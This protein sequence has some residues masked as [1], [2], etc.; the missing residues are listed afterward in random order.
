MDRPD[1][2]VGN[3]VAVEIAQRGQGEAKAIVVAQTAD[4]TSL[5]RADLPVRLHRPVGVEEQHPHRATISAPVVI[6][7][8][9]D[10]QV[11]DAVAVQI[12]QRGHR[13]AEEIAIAQDARKAALGIADLPVRLDR[14]VRVEE[15]HPHRAAVRAPVVVMPRSHGQVADAIAVEIAKRGHRSAEAIAIDQCAGEAALGVADLLVRQHPAGLA[16]RACCDQRGERD[17][18]RPFRNSTSVHIPSPV[19]IDSTELLKYH[20]ERLPRFERASQSRYFHLEQSMPFHH[21]TM[22]YTVWS[23]LISQGNESTMPASL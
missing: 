7:D 16:K 21:G 10:G 2:Q 17:R 5:R 13:G 8:R 22:I 20:D 11:A 14:P 18:Q 12:A 3:A 19:P 6:L 23:K 1:G 9:P 15:Q 4:K